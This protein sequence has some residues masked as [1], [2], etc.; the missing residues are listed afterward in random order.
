MLWQAIRF[1]IAIQYIQKELFDYT[2]LCTSNRSIYPSNR[3]SRWI[4]QSNQSIYPSIHGI[5]CFIHR[6]NRF[7]N[8]I[9]PLIHR[10]DPYIH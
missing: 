8:R 9:D 2:D 4:Y 3:M 10:I 5:H 6:F 1:R 7:I